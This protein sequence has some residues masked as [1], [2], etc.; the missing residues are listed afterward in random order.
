M[1]KAK[2][3]TTKPRPAFRIYSVTKDGEKSNWYEIGAA[4]AHS[5][6]KGFG[7]QF[8]AI[9]VSGADVV[10]RVPKEKEEA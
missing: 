5:D 9:P 2:E 1:R 6:G 7:L 4:W 3:E 8:G 10:L